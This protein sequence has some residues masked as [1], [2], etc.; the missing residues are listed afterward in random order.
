MLNESIEHIL[1]V[2]SIPR[3]NGQVEK[4]NRVITPMLAKICETPAK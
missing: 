1:I 4:F 2:V 3:A